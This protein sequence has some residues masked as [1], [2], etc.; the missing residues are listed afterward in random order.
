MK[1]LNLI[2]IVAIL[3]LVMISYAA[4]KP[5]SQVTKKVVKITLTQAIKEPGLVKAIHTQLKMQSLQVE[6]HSLYVGIVVYNLVVYKIY[7]SR[8]QWIR[9]FLETAKTRIGTNNRLG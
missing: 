8:T 3:S 1:T 2:M 5:T 6:P 7:G 4:V 9:F